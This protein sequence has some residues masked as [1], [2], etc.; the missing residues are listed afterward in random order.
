MR[1]K[2]TLP[3]VFVAVGLVL[4]LIVGLMS[5]LLPL[6]GYGV[7]PEAVLDEEDDVSIE[8]PYLPGDFQ[9]EDS[10]WKSYTHN[11]EKALRG[12]DISE[13]QANI[14]WKALKQAGADFA[15]IRM[16]YRGY[17]DGGLF[18][19]AHF[20]SNVQAALDAGLRVGVYFFSQAITT[21]EAVEEAEFVLA[22][23]ENLDIT[24]PIAYDWETVAADARTDTLSGRDMTACALAFCDTIRAAGYI[25]AIYTNQNQGLL[26][27]GYAEEE[28]QDI[29]IWLADYNDTPAFRYDFQMWQYTDAGTLPGIDTAVD[30]NLSFTN[31]DNRWKFW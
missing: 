31:F 29:V 30:L 15:M 27:Y 17:T 14:D 11:G 25:P 24:W 12:V 18:E 26:Y 20:R 22:A 21:E 9:D 19:D 28:L 6:L 2:Q 4:L 23:L 13:H 7:E 3:V 10:G 16:G 8:Q 5:L 1:R